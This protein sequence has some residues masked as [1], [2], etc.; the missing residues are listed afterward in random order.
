MLEMQKYF[1]ECII[2][3]TATHVKYHLDARFAFLSTVKPLSD[4]TSILSP[5]F[6]FKANCMLS[7]VLSNE[8][9]RVKFSDRLVNLITLRISD[10][11][12]P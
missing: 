4:L 11:H 12:A 8:E 3:R 5:C 2:K 1:L 7:E 6:H 10:F 9:C